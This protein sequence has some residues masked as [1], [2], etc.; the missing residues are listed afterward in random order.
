MKPFISLV[1]LT[2]SFSA[3]LQAAEIIVGNDLL[4][5]GYKDGAS[6]T[7]VSY[8]GF[9]VAAIGSEISAWSMYAHGGTVGA[10]ITPLLF[11]YVSGSN[12]TLRAIGE[13]YTVGSTGL[14]TD[15]AFNVQAGSASILSS[16]YYFGWK[17][18]TQTSANTGVIS[19]DLGGGSFSVAALSGNSTQNVTGSDVGTDLT[20][21][22]FLGTRIYS[23]QA[24]T[25]DAVAANV[26]LAAPYVLMLAGLLGGYGRR[27][28]IG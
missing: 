2:L 20:F 17:D 22:N 9:G 23:F 3:P 18:G 12:F 26:P 7:Y 15:I 21:G 6:T 28:F 4:P 1:L 11:E 25:A 10:N 27:R 14:H 13:T 16:D 8:D 24:K 5:R 19:M